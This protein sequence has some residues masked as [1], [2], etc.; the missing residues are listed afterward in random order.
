MTKFGQHF[1]TDR[2]VLK[3]MVTLVSRYGSPEI[4]LEIGPGKGIL[5]KELAK[6]AK[7]VIAVE[8]DR[9]LEQY[10]SPI[11]K[12]YPNVEVIYGDI[13][14]TNLANLGLKN[15]NY[16]LASNLPYDITGAVLRQFLTQL[17]YPSHIAL[18][19]QKEVAERI[20]AKPGQLSVLG[21][22]IQAFALPRIVRIVP[23]SAFSPKPKVTSA[24]VS[25]EAI[26]TQTWLST[27]EEKIFFRLVRAGFAQKRK[28]LSSNLQNF[29]SNGKMIPKSEIQSA[30]L[31]IGLAP[32]ARAQE[33]SLEQWL[34]LVDKLQ[35]FVV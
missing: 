17:P 33:L 24:I 22:S 12:E 23:P 32:T 27:E 31:A 14:R 18:L 35:N 7:R 13:L 8:I 15:G 1:L 6:L 28:L 34:Q 19:I 20:V 25:I 5:T 9:T 21:L 29:N 2:S 16:S 4:I 3:E 11:Q 26:R 10:L 30:F